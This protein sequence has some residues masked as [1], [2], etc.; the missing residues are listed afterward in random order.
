[1]TFPSASSA[2]TIVAIALLVSVPTTGC[3]DN[4]GQGTVAVTIWGEDFIEQGIPA[5]EL[6]DGWA[7]TFDTFVVNV[8]AITAAGASLPELRTFDLTL[9]GPLEVGSVA[10]AEGAIRPV[11]FALEPVDDT[12]QNVNVDPAIF[13][14]MRAAG[15]SVYVAGAAT[16]DGSTVQFTWSFDVSVTYHDCLAADSVPD[17]GTGTTQLTIHGDHLFYDSLV[18][19]GAALRFQ[20][21]ADADA[22]ADGA[23][24]EAELRALSGIPF[25]ALDHYD[26]PAGSEID[27]LWDYLAAQVTTLGHIDGEGH[28]D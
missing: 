27:N 11:S 28:C 16:R 13:D 1:M 2:A 4:A 14:A 24:T 21:Y 23:V 22:D 6:A 15:T 3:S 8:G 20:A 18:D 7:V 26:V 10:A 17:G 9:A 25:L 12:A 5:A 19:H